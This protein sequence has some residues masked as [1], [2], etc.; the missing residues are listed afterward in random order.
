MTRVLPLACVLACVLLIWMAAVVPMNWDQAQALADD[1]AQWQ[2]VAWATLSLDR[3]LLPAPHQVAGE[4]IGSIA[5]WPVTSPR[6]LVF[7]AVVTFAAAVVG[8]VL[9]LALGVALAVGIVHVRTLD[10]AL[11]PWVIASQ[12]V[13]VLAIAPMVVV[14]LGNLGLTGLLPKALIAG[15]L[16]FFPI[17]TGMVKGLRSPDPMQR[18]L[19]RTYSATPRQEFAKLRWPASMP[20]LFPGLKVAAPLALVGA[21]VAE[22]PTG[23]QAGLGA[24]LLA[25][26]YYGQTLQIWAALFMAAVLAVLAVAAVDLAQAVMLSR[27]GGRL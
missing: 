8:F 20:F 26:S 6:S 25:G 18:D 9:A 4:L 13:P 3:P 1:G 14:V 23:A 11:M 12:A 16:S 17:T 5:G 21:I 7:H 27:R 22:L 10:R 24:R 2:D 15:W 19:M